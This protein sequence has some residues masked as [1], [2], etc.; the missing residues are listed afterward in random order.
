M[1]LNKKT[2]YDINCFAQGVVQAR[3]IH[4][5]GSVATFRIAKSKSDARWLQ[6]GRE[7]EVWPGRLEDR[8][9][10]AKPM[11]LENK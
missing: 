1:K 7:L 5:N 9:S 10:K 4:R 2:L 8:V 3:L 6:V 11:M